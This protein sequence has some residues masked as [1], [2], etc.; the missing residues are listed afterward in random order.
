MNGTWML[1]IDQHGGK[2][3]ARTVRELC[4]QFDRKKAHRQYSD[5]RAGTFHTGYIIAGHWLTAYVPYRGEP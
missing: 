2:Y 5:T 4:E 3:G 1:Y